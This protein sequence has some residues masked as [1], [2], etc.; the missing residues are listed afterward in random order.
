MV[1]ATISMIVSGYWHSYLMKELP[2]KA[3]ETTAAHP[4]PVSLLAGRIG[5]YIDKMSLVWVEGEIIQLSLRKDQYTSYLTLREGKASLSVSIAT[6]D[7]LALGEAL[8]EGATAVAHVKARFWSTSGRF[9]M[10]AKQLHI[11][12]EGELLAR[13]EQ[14]KKVLAAEGLFA[15]ERKLPL[16]FLPRKVGLICGRDSKAMHDVVVNARERWPAVSFEIREVA[17]QGAN[18]VREVSGALVELDGLA[19][20]EVIVIARGGGSVE[21]LLGFS[22]EALVRA[23]AACRTPVVSAVGHETDNPLIDFVADL[24]ASTPTDAAKRIVPA[25]AEERRSLHEAQARMKRALTSRLERE[26]LA[27]D[28]YRNRTTLAHPDRVL[29]EYE[30]DVFAHRERAQRAFGHHLTLANGELSG[31]KAQLTALSPQATLE[32]GYAIVT[33]GTEIVRAASQVDTG[34]RLS[35]RVLQGQIEAAVTTAQEMGD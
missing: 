9:V 35:I 24:R 29:D 22:N 19:N 6:K 1:S 23:V 20:V 34:Q 8:Q 11:R 25:I 27:L 26:Q 3:A 21:D 16:P 13:I 7:L 17:V 4:W 33:T 28:T 2:T 15:P 5:E 12:G 30:V 31:L 18:V 14:L 32:R 10:A